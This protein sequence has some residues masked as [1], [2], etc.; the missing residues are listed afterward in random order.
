MGN[1]IVNTL[2]KYWVSY[3]QLIFI[4]W[5]SSLKHLRCWW[6]ALQNLIRYS[7]IFNVQLYVHLKKWTLKFKLLYLLNHI[8]Y[9]DKICRICCLNTRIQSLKIWLK[10]VLQLLI[11]I[12]F[13]RGLFFIGAP[14]RPATVYPIKGSVTLTGIRF[15]YLCLKRYVE[16]S[17]QII[18]SHLFSFLTSVSAVLAKRGNKVKDIVLFHIY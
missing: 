16:I 8:S 1:D 2:F 6:K 11:Y 12:I 4:I 14:C 15:Q 9:F 10:S 17:K 18:F 7:W 13:S 3:R 5:Y